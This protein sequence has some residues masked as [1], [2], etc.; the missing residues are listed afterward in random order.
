MKSETLEKLKLYTKEIND[1]MLLAQSSFSIV[2]YLLRRE[3]DLEREVIN[4]NQFLKFSR[5]IYWRTYVTELSKLFAERHSDHFNL[6]DFINKFKEG[7]EF[8]IKEIDEYSIQIWED[9][10]KLE[11]K[12]ID[13]LLLQ[14]DKRYGHTDRKRAHVKNELTFEDAE[15]LL[16]V[17]QRIVS[18]IYR[19][20]FNTFNDFKVIGDP[21]HDL[22]KLVKVLADNKKEMLSDF[23][24]HC[25]EMDIDPKEVGL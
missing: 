7:K 21:V 12:K 25:E 17:V 14:R 5:E 20:V 9:N 8:E 15:E 23:R 22:K 1:I 4:Q 24:K 11:K 6:H 3:D 18:E 19:V 10:L 16:R 13:N 2:Y